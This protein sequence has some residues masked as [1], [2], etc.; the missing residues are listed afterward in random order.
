MPYFI[1]YN[2]INLQKTIIL[3]SPFDTFLHALVAFIPE[4]LNSLVV[5]FLSFFFFS[6]GFDFPRQGFSV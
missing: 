5:T 1:F 2:F 4:N 6:F 3:G